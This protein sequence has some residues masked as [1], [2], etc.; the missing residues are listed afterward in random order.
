MTLR[1]AASHLRP[2]PAAEQRFFAPLPLYTR[3][4]SFPSTGPPSPLPQPLPRGTLLLLHKLE[5]G[6]LS[7]YSVP[8]QSRAAYL[9]VRRRP[10]DI[11]VNF[12]VYLFT[13]A[14]TAAQQRVLEPKLNDSAVFANHVSLHL[15]LIFAPCY[16]QA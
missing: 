1:M 6:A 10:N 12:T 16:T 11:K 4:E 2:R 7:C 8:V 5:L 13:V 9:P 3:S 15:Y 14:K